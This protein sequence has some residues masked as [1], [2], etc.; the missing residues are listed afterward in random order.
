[1]ARGPR[2]GTAAQLRARLPQHGGFWMA[3]GATA[4]LFG[5]LAFLWAVA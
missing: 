2:G 1:M 5:L 3:I 4:V